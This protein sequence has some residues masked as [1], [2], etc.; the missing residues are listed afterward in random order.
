MT[1]FLVMPDLEAIASKTLRD[2]G[3]RA[4]S[5]VPSNP[6]W[7]LMVISRAGGFIPVRRYLDAA[8]IQIDVWGGAKGDPAG[9]TSKS[10]IQDMAQEARV[11]LH[12]LE[13]TSVVDPVAAFITG[14]ED[15][16]GLTWL[17]D[18]DTGRDRYIFAVLI[19]G[20]TLYEASS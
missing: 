6:E 14:V 17:P 1:D 5:S 18:P 13:G 9:G 19:Y 12:R 4:Y 16:M 2:A 15:A 11:E 8:R 3:W 10:V 7:P 20:R